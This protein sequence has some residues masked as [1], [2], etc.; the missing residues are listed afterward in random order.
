[1]TSCDNPPVVSDPYTALA[2]V[3]E[4]DLLMRYGPMIGNDDLLQALGYLS[5]DAFRQA[6][7]RRQL[8]VPVFPLANRRGKY[9]LA[10]DVAHWLASVRAHAVLPAGSAASSS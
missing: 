8:P 6:L 3:L 1:M 9:A 7:V 4:R 10:K 5:L 2:N